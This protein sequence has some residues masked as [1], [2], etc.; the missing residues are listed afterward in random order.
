MTSSVTELLLASR[1]A[2]SFEYGTLR[3]EEERMV[4]EGKLQAFMSKAV[5][6]LRAAISG[7]MVH[8]G[9]ELGLYRVMAGAGRLTAGRA[10]RWGG[11]L[12]VGS[13]FSRTSAGGRVPRIGWSS[14]SCITTPIGE[15]RSSCAASDEARTGTATCNPGPPGW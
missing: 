3:T 11:C 10:G 4:D 5:S 7:L 15:S 2:R 14:R 6:D 12:A 8:I 1:C 9:D 13:Y